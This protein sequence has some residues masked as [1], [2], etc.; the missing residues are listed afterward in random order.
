MSTPPLLRGGDMNSQNRKQLNTRAAVAIAGGALLAL[1]GFMG[2][3]M[4]WSLYFKTFSTY[5]KFFQNIFALG[6]AAILEVGLFWFGLQ[7][8]KSAATW[9]ERIVAIAG[10]VI[11][12]VIIGM[13]IATHNAMMRGVRLAEWQSNYVN[14]FGPAVIAVV[15]LLVLVQ[16]VLRPEVQAAFRDTMRNFE[17]KSRLDEIEDKVLD[18]PEFDRWMSENFREEIYR[19]AANRAGYEAGRHTLPEAPKHPALYAN[20]TEVEEHSDHPGYVNGQADIYTGVQSDI[21]R[22]GDSL[23]K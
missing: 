19:R 18:S 5:S 6:T 17:T 16:L 10:A 3:M 15:A 20:T 11:I 14:Y 4:G 1:I 21:R 12:L 8:I 7:L 9:G 23:P 22:R 2:V 13:N